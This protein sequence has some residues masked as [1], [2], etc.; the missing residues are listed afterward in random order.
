MLSEAVTRA[1]AALDRLDT[2]AGPGRNLRRAVA[3]GNG[4]ADEV[5]IGQA[6]LLR[7]RIGGRRGMV[8]DEGCGPRLGRADGV[9][10]H[11]LTFR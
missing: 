10:R 11:D 2:L 1:A 6:Q 9:V 7:R 3:F 4:K 5:D 8:G